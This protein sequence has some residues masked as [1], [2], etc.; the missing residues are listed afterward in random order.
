MTNSQELEIQLVRKRK[1]KKA[2][3][4]ALCISEMALLNKMKGKSEFKASEISRTATFLDLT[5]DE[6]D[7]I[8]FACDVI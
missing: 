8:F 3:A 7:S 5:R 4:N 2:L 1:S 6:R